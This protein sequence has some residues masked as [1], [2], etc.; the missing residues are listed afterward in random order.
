MSVLWSGQ[1]TGV[2]SHAPDGRRLGL[3]LELESGRVGECARQDVTWDAGQARAL[4]SKRGLGQTL[5]KRQGRMRQHQA[6]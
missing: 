1:S 6:G 4:D 2:T 3:D 5:P